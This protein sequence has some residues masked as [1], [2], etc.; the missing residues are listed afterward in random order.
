MDAYVQAF[1]SQGYELSGS[2]E[3]EAGFEKVAIYRGRDG[4]PSHMAR[5]LPDGRW[6]CKLGGYVDIAHASPNE[7]EGDQYGSLACVLRRP[8]QY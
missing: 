7:L 3:L 2:V 6:T 1:A 4:F 8:T 5:Q